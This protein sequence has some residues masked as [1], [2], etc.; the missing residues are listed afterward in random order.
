MLQIARRS[1]LAAPGTR[2]AATQAARRCIW[3]LAE[4][5]EAEADLTVPLENIDC[6]PPLFDATTAITGDARGGA[7]VNVPRGNRP[8]TLFAAIARAI[9]APLGALVKRDRDLKG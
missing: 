8:R 2:A 4:K 5:S 3:G 9:V 6:P 7:G 1:R